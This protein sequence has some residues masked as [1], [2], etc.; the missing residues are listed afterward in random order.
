[1]PFGRAAAAPTRPK[2]ERLFVRGLFLWTDRH[3]KQLSGHYNRPAFRSLD[4]LT[5]GPGPGLL[6]LYGH[7]HETGQARV[8]IRTKGLFKALVAYEVMTTVRLKVRSILESLF[9]H[10]V[11]AEVAQDLVRLRPTIRV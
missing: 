6:P 10:L 8:G 3:Q 11:F 5:Y 7:G 4:R 1:M 9:D 2:V